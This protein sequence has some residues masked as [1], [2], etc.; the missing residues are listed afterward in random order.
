M[1]ANH[2]PEALQ[3]APTPSIHAPRWSATAY[4]SAYTIM[5]NLFQF[6][7]PVWGA[8]D[9]RKQN[10]RRFYV[11]IHAPRV[12]C[13]LHHRAVVQSASVVSIH[14]PRA[15]CD[16]LLDIRQRCCM[17]FNS[18]TPCGVRPI[19]ALTRCP[20]YTFQFT[21]PVRGATKYEALSLALTTFQFTHPVRG[22]TSFVLV[23]VDSY[24]VS[25][26]AP[27][28]GCDLSSAGQE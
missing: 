5:L 17:R 15:G 6:T 16:Y 12:G 19:R 11:S 23:L 2:S 25:I 26:H 10:D 18:R 21:H 13:D 1:P 24:R 28:A 22:A 14:A 27:R 9:G 3:S 4:E 20:L 8:T 7:H